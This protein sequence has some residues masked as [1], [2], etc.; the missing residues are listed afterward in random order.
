MKRVIVLWGV[1]GTGKTHTRLNDPELRDL[2]CV[3]IADVYKEFPEA[4]WLMAYGIMERRVA[5]LLQAHDAIV[6]E[7]YFLPGSTTRRYL[8]W[9]LK[10]AGAE[11]EYRECWAP[12][13]VC[14][15]RIADQWERGEISAADCKRRIELLGSCW[16]R[17][18]Q[19]HEE[20]Q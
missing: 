9:A 20:A 8:G 6:A 13:E 14:A 10:V 18:T 2:P 12:L 3:D 15:Q 11:P 16:H 1:S 4:D 17:Q 5:K 19:L 7:G